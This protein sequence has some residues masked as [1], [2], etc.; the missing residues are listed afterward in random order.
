MDIRVYL[1]EGTSY[2]FSPSEKIR[3]FLGQQVFGSELLRRWISISLALGRSSSLP[4]K[5]LPNVQAVSIKETFLDNGVPRERGE[6]R[7]RTAT[8]VLDFVVK[9]GIYTFVLEVEAKTLQDLEEAY[10]LIR[11]GRLRPVIS[12]EAPMVPP[13][14]QTIRRLLNEMAMVVKRDIQTW[15]RKK[16]HRVA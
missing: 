1:K 8:A 7:Y 12:Y 11:G 4:E 13:F 2:T 3:L 6:Y 16:V 10:S 5:L 9:T 15:W 14:P